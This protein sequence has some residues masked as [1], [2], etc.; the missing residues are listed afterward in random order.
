MNFFLKNI[1]TREAKPRKHGLTSVM[2]LGL[3]LDEAKRL[4]KTVG[5]HIDIIKLG[6]GIAYTTPNLKKK[7]KIYQKYDIKVHFGG[8]IFEAFIARNQ[9][10]D[11]VKLIK[12]YK[13]NCVEV[14]NGIMEI[15]HAEKCDYIKKLSK[16]TKVISEVGSKQETE[17]INFK[18]WINLI[19]KEL[20]AGAWKVTTEGRYYG[21]I[22][23]YN[24]DGSVRKNLIKQITKKIS[25]DKI[26]W[27]APKDKQQAW[28]ISELGCDVNLGNID[29]KDVLSLETMRLGLR[30]DTFWSNLKK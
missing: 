23:I 9:F 15:N 22:G 3:D 11:F 8:T 18:I 16:I 2:D 29:P 26:I 30:A 5:K 1:P 10:D 21:D 20:E 19:K 6:M 24:K 13:L 25:Q 12:T 7:I 4:V 27:E 28:F 14:A 17:E